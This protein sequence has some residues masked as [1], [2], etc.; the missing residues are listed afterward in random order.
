MRQVPKKAVSLMFVFNKQ[1]SLNQQICL[2]LQGKQRLIKET[3]RQMRI[4]FG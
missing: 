2:L 1:P 3:S 4:I